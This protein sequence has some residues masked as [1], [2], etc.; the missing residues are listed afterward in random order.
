[1]EKVETGV[2]I[3]DVIDNSPA[4]DAGILPGDIVIRAEGVDMYSLSIDEA[5]THI[6]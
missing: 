1:M 5:I 3:N 4:K 6:K 2:R